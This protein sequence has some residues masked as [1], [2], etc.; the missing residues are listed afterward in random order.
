MQNDLFARIWPMKVFEKLDI[1]FYLGE[2]Y[3][4]VEMNKIFNAKNMI[5]LK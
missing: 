2:W 4:L 5:T 1:V 3:I